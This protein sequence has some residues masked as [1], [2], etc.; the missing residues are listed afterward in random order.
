MAQY[1]YIGDGSVRVHFHEYDYILFD[2][3]VTMYTN[4]NVIKINIVNEFI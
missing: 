2:I 3:I 1:G 4:D